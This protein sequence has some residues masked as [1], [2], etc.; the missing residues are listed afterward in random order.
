MKC[1]IGGGLLSLR[2]TVGGAAVR[3]A[4]EGLR[5]KNRMTD[6]PADRRRSL[7]V[8]ANRPSYRSWQLRCLRRGSS[9]EPWMPKLQRLT[10]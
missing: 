6:G 1:R 4:E 10:C 9:F 2:R 3:N 8:W 5:E 7:Y